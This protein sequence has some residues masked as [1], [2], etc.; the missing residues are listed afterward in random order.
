MI[1]KYHLQCKL[2]YLIKRYLSNQN[3]QNNQ[4][5]NQFDIYQ[6]LVFQQKIGSLFR[7]N[8]QQKLKDNLGIGLASQKKESNQI[9]A[10]QQGCLYVEFT[11]LDQKEMPFIRH[12]N[13][14][15]SKSM[16]DIF[17]NTQVEVQMYLT[18]PVQL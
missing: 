16:M 2:V 11:R 10:H 5:V 3:N 15:L 8:G 13:A 12:L 17:K 4:Q 18:N 1:T 9:N 6:V 14:L 7:E